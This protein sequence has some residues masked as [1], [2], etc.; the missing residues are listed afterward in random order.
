MRLVSLRVMSDRPPPSAY[1][2][3]GV[4]LAA[5]DDAL[6]RIRDAVASTYTPGVLR[7][8]GAFGGLFA[9]PSGYREPVLVASTDGVGTKTRL[10]VALGAV[11]G[12]GRDLVNH[13][14]NDILV[15]G[16]KPLFFLDYVASARLEPALIA[17]VVGGMADACRAS[18]MALLGGETAE[19]PGVYVAGE[20]DLVGTIV[21][22]VERSEIIDGASVTA[23]DVLL[24]LDSGGLQTN[25]FS[26]ARALAA[27]HEHT[28]VQRDDS[29]GVTLGAALLAPH[30]SFERALRPLIEA[31][32]VRALAHITG[33]GLPGNVPRVLPAGLA[34]DIVV[35][36]WR[37][38]PVFHRLQALGA[39]SDAE[40]RQV[41][42]LGVG[43]VVVVAAGEVARAQALCPELLTPI[44]RVVP[45]DGVHF[46]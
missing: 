8:L 18:Q 5:A 22:V 24:A 20:L 39:V 4:D 38:P 32:L 43:M 16:A 27:G 46:S 23:G 17:E 3:A 33:G 11:R 29:A 30:R 14:L 40:M 31:G 12:L 1:A 21:G 6:A 9:L 41:F 13:C 25:G 36:S 45:G 28:P 44:G 37:V 15:Q 35:G 19:M 10:A 42:N 7:G 26:L 2:A 34:A